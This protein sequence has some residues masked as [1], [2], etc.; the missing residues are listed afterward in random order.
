LSKTRKPLNVIHGNVRITKFNKN[1]GNPVIG[2][3][4]VTSDV[5]G[6]LAQ[7]LD[8]APYGSVIASTNTGTTTAARQFIGQY[9]DANS[10]L[11][12]LQNRYYSPTQGQF[13]T[14]DP[15][16]LSL[17]NP[18]QVQQLSEHNQQT[19]LENPQKLNSYSY[20]QDNPINSKDPSGLSYIQLAYMNAQGSVFGTTGIRIDQYGIVYFAGAGT[21]VGEEEGGDAELSAGTLSHTPQVNNENSVT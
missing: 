13:L 2:S 8:Y 20:S 11:S 17:G 7:S 1:R 6:N 15:V 12:Y 16:S 9:Y 4:A 19:L 3:T 18:N 14:E 10:G 5:N 21:G